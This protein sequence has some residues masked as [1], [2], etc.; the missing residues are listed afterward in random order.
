MPPLHPLFTVG[1]S[2]RTIEQ[3]LQL[4]GAHGVQVVADVR[5]QPYSRRFAHFG[6]Q[7]LQSA[8]KGRGLGYVFLG[9]ELGARRTEPECYLE[10]RADYGLI[11]RSPAFRAGL[12]RVLQEAARHRLAL[13]CAERDPLACHRTVLVCRALRTE[14]P[15]IRHILDLTEVETQAQVE[16]RLQREEG[17]EAPQGDLFASVGEALDRAYEARGARLCHRRADASQGPASQ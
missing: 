3:F 2:S 12:Q 13:M 17:E 1:H 9:S 6:R 8:L 5:S 15:D 11:A 10:G 7:A 4:L 16:A 14:Q